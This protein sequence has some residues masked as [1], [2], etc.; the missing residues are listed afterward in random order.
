MTSI[1]LRWQH[2]GGRGEMLNSET[3]NSAAHLAG[4]RVGD[5][6]MDQRDSN[7]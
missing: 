4:E 7:P 1:I 5:R 6:P 2:H 3:P